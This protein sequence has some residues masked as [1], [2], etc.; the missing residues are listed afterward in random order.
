VLLLVRSEAPEVDWRVVWMTGKLEFVEETVEVGK[1]RI[2]VAICPLENGWLLLVSDRAHRIGSVGVGVPTPFGEL[3]PVA[4]AC[5]VGPR[6]EPAVRAI[7]DIAAHKLNGLVI[8]NLFLSRE[9]EPAIDV[10]LT[11]VRRIL[12]KVKRPE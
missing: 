12:L 4:T 10:A 11:A 8:V 1:M 5:V 3:G 7:A 9:N 2:S 6:F